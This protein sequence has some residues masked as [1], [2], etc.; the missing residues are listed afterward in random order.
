MSQIDELIATGTD[1]GSH[2][3]GNK[4]PGRMERRILEMLSRIGSGKLEMYLPDGDIRIFEGE[5]GVSADISI[6]NN[7]IFRRSVQGGEIGLA[8]SYM[9]GDWTSRDLT[10]LLRLLLQNEPQ[11]EQKVLLRFARGLINRLQHLLN[12]N[13]TRGSRRNIAYHYDLGNDFYRLWLDPSMTYSA[14]LFETG[15]EDL[16][17][18]QNV[19]YDRIAEWADLSDGDHLLEIGCGWGGFAERVLAGRDVELTGLTLS[20]EQLSYANN[21]L[22]KVG[23]AERADLR[24]QDYRHCDGKYD[25]VVS[26]EMFEAVGRKYWDRYFTALSQRLKAGGAAVLQVITIEEDRFDRYSRGADFIQKYIFPGGFLPTNRALIELAERHGFRH[27]ESLM[28]GLDYARTLREWHEAFEAHW[29]ALEKMGF[30]ERF[31][32]MW[33]FYLSY[34]EA[35]FLEGSIDVGLFRF[36]QPE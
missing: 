8:E 5:T 19:K 15:V 14:A 35:G 29:P 1:S 32:R 18:A 24:L 11:L 27:E 4:G 20:Q 30:D 13:S 2:D 7:R 22:A 26:I 9:D 10:A 16:E 12:A 25:A 6:H 33:R 21:R 28:F 36:R 23:L 34:C 3:A 31:R 17:Q